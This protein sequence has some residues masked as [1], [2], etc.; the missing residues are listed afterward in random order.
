MC[1]FLCIIVAHIK[2]TGL[3][4]C[5]CQFVSAAKILKAHEAEGIS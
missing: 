2:H 3:L 1:A 4:S 5:N